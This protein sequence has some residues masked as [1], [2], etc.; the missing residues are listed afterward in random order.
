MPRGGSRRRLTQPRLPPVGVYGP[1]PRPHRSDEEDEEDKPF[2]D[3]ETAVTT[4]PCAGPLPRFDGACPA[5]RMRLLESGD[6]ASGEVFWATQ[7]A[8][9]LD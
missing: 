7:A 9:T 3:F 1:V 2:V 8:P 6:T 5:C 4:P